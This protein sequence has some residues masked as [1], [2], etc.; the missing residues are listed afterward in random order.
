MKTV[1]ELANRSVLTNYNFTTL[2]AI[3]QNINSIGFYETRLEQQ[4]KNLTNIT[5]AFYKQGVVALQWGN[6]ATREQKLQADE[7]QMIF[8]GIQDMKKLNQTEITDLQNVIRN[9]RTK[10]DQ[11]SLAHA[12]KLLRDSK[13]EQS[14]SIDEYKQQIK[15]LKEEINT[16]KLL[17]DSMSKATG[18]NDPS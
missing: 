7:L 15:S 8:T 2:K 13:T 10:F 14:Q 6:H 11:M 3:F 16:M 17:Y 5:E 4:C 1:K 9:A 18:C 12:L